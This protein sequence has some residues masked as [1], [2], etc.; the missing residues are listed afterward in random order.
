MTTNNNTETKTP[1]KMSYNPLNNT[2][3]TLEIK[4]KTIENYVNQIRTNFYSAVKA[5][6]LVARDLFDAKENLNNQ[7]FSELVKQCKFSGSTQQKYLR[8]GGDVRLMSLFIVGKLPMNWTTQYLLTQLKDS[9]FKKVAKVIN[10]DTTANKIREVAEMTDVEKQKVENDILSFLQVEVDKTEVDVTKFKTL[11]DK[12]KSAL[13][14]FPEININDE[15]VESVQ[16]KILSY[17][18]KLKKEEEQKQKQIEK[19]N[20][21]RAI[22]AKAQATAIAA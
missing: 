5:H 21:A 9:Q 16:S 6:Y 19:E 1:T 20:M 14:S 3:Q 4:D 10:P 11:V 8:V 15:K 22:L 17:E 12:I 13:S 7:D 18:N 2:L